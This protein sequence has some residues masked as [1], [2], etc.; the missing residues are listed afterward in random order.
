VHIPNKGHG[1]GS[2]VKPRPQWRLAENG[3]YQTVVAD[4][5]D[6]SRRNRRLGL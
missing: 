5:G 2:Q 3:D 1:F 4:S 6:Y